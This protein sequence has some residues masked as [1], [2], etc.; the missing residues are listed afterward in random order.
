VLAGQAHVHEG[1]D[2]APDHL[3]AE[4]VGLDLE[5]QHAVAHVGPACAAHLADQRGLCALAV[6]MPGLAAERREVVLPDQRIAAQPQQLDGQWVRD[7]PGQPGE[8]RIGLGPVDDCVAV[9]AAHGRAPGVEV[10]GGR[11][12]V[13]HDDGR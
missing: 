12:Q 9:G 4:G 10:V 1:A 5:A 6:A 11:A 8:E 13:T 3:V 2:D 7:M